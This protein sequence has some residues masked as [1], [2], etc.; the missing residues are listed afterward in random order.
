MLGNRI[1]LPKCEMQEDE[2]ALMCASGGG[3]TQIVRLL[4]EHKAQKEAKKNVRGTKHHSIAELARLNEY[5][6]FAFC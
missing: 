1:A 6:C 4:L 2:T 3:H 5:Q